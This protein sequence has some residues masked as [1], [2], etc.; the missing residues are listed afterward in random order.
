MK[1]RVISAIIALIIVIPIIIYGGLPYYL[2]VA[3]V[4]A[5]GYYEMIKVREK[6]KKISN[7]VEVLSMI[8]F[9]LIVLSPGLKETNFTVDYRLF[10][11][12]LF[13]CFLPLIVLDRKDY[14]A[15]D[16]LVLCAATM[17]LGISFS[18]LITIRNISVLYL[19]YVVLITIM[20]DT[21][22]HFFGTQIGRHKLA[23]KVSPNK[24]VE[25]MVG[26]V[27]S[28]FFSTFINQ[29]ANLFYVI[30][31]SLALSII[32]EF[33]DL[34]FSSIKRRYGVKDYGNIM[35]GHGGV[36]DRLDSILFAVL[37]FSY[38]VSFF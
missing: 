6:E 7:G 20:S 35:P 32:A 28:V 26:G 21:F 30:V 4:A 18:F 15:E 17:F 24:T 23:P 13:V 36:L 16:A 33:G 37:A 38:L 10:I 11:L 25:G 29:N 19:V 34:V 9:L 12:N 14:D 5:I 3:L 2:G 22:A 27:A 1:Q 8:S 31:I